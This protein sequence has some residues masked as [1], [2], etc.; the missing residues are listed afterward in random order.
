MMLACDRNARARGR[1]QG[2]VKFFAR[3]PSHFPLKT[4]CYEENYSF[5][6]STSRGHRGDDSTSLRS[7]DHDHAMREADADSPRL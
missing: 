7:H 6:R 5:V 2:V 1:V 3:T 4:I